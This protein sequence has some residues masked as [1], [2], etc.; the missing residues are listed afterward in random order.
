[1]IIYIYFFFYFSLYCL[2]SYY[3]FSSLYDGLLLDDYGLLDNEVYYLLDYG[4]YG[5]ICNANSFLLIKDIVGNCC[6]GLV[7]LLLVYDFVLSSSL[8]YYY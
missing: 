2:I 3:S 4:I 6:I 7:L 8:T 5:I 1:M